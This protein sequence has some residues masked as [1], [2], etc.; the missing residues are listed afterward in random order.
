[1]LAKMSSE[2]NLYPLIAASVGYIRVKADWGR[3]DDQPLYDSLMD[4]I[5]M[6]AAAGDSYLNLSIAESGDSQCSMPARFIIGNAHHTI[7]VVLPV[8]HRGD[9]GSRRITH[10]HGDQAQFLRA[11]LLP[12]DRNRPWVST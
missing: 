3:T 12:I 10:C 4:H 2:T 6:S 7:H 5:Q 9:T 1:M 11:G 8:G